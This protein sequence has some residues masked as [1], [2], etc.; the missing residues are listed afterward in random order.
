[1]TANEAVLS[2]EDKKALIEELKDLDII[3][4]TPSIFRERAFNYNFFYNYNGLIFITPINLVQ[5]DPDEVRPTISD[6][7]AWVR[8]LIVEEK[9]EL[10]KLFFSKDPVYDFMFTT[11]KTE[12]FRLLQN[13]W[14]CYDMAEDF[15]VCGMD[16]VDSIDPEA[17]LVF[18][19]KSPMDTYKKL[20]NDVGLTQEKT[21][22]YALTYKHELEEQQSSAL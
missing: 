16:V 9:E 17:D 6:Y 21:I 12:I 14:V 1:M 19:K 8:D 18:D 5:L 11:Q 7:A 4:L 22:K 20:L 2:A 3:S 13:Q 15:D 10:D